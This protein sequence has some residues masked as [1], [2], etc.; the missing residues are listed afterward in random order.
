MHVVKFAYQVIEMQ[1][2]ID[3]LEAEVERL[4]DYERK[5]HKE[6]DASIKHGEQMMCGWIDLLLSDRVKLG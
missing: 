6:I 2:R 3:Y 5:Y 4:R 1:E